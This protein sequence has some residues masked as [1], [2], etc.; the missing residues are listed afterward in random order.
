MKYDWSL[1][2]KTFFMGLL[3]T[4]A[5]IILVISSGW[6]EVTLIC[7]G[8]GPFILFC[9]LA[10]TLFYV[11]MARVGASRLPEDWDNLSPEAKHDFARKR[12]IE[13]NSRSSKAM[14][15]MM[16]VNDVQRRKVEEYLAERED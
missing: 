9:S 2:R 10:V 4:V 8:I 15:W 7:L 16:R 6:D 1:V 13:K 3:M 12:L 11:W 5:G 14:L